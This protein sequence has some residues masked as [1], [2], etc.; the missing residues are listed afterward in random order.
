VGPADGVDVGT[1]VG[2]VAGLSVSAVVGDSVGVDVGA[3]V[4]ACSTAGSK[5]A[6]TSTGRLVL[7]VAGVTV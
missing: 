4:V 3:L 5:V 2:D 1:D 6:D 7:L